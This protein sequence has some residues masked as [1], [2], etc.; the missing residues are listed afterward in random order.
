LGIPVL[1]GSEFKAA[2]WLAI[3]LTVSS[4]AAGVSTILEE[5]FRGLGRPEILFWSEGAAGVTIVLL[6]AAFGTPF[7]V[8]GIAIAHTAGAVM[9]TA[10]LLTSMRRV[11]GCSLGRLCVPM[12]ADFSRVVT[13][14]LAR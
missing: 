8:K 5:G 12:R 3:V 13:E 1:F 7:G 10:V 6:F 14:V 2:V 9:S 11:T 4:A